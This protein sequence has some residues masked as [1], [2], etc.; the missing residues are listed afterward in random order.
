MILI[1]FPVMGDG[2]L[3][4]G[5]VAASVFKLKPEVYS[6]F[7]FKLMD[8]GVRTVES[9]KNIAV[10]LGINKDQLEEVLKSTYPDT[11]LARARSMGMDFK[12][13]GT[14]FIIING[15][16]FNQSLD[17]DSIENF[18]KSNN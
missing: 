3:A 18:I 6:D 5:A 14:P 17:M 11:Y 4:L 10:G 9:A 12:V 16:V 8:E 13:Q 1:D 15:K 7:Y 2:S